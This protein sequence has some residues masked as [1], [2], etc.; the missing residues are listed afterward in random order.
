MSET[1]FSNGSPTQVLHGLRPGFVNVALVIGQLVSSLSRILI[2]I[3]YR[4]GTPD[5]L[6]LSLLVD[7][8]SSH[9]VAKYNS[10]VYF[11]K[12]DLGNNWKGDGTAQPAQPAQPSSTA[13]P[14]NGLGLLNPHPQSPPTS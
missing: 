10:T 8:L 2:S 14:L 3:D 7:Y 1:V 11:S 6:R 13:C 12:P 4:T 9:V 5:R